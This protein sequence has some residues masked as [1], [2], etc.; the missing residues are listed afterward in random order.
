MRKKLWIRGLALLYVFALFFSLETFAGNTENFSDTATQYQKGVT[1]D[2]NQTENAIE[3][4][5]EVLS[6]LDLSN[7]RDLIFSCIKDSSQS[8]IKAFGCVIAVIFIS[9]VFAI[10]KESFSSF[11]QL[12]DTVGM[13]FLILFTLIPIC[14][15]IDAIEENI[16]RLCAFM[17][18]FIP[19]MTA[20]YVSGGNTTTAVSSSITCTATVGALQLI[21]SKVIIPFVKLGVSLSAVNGICRKADLSGVTGFLRSAGLWI[22]GLS[23]TI[24]T[25]LLSVQ[26]LISNSTDTLALRGIRFS[27]AK[28]IPVAGGMVSESLKTVLSGVSLVRNVAGGAGI[29]FIIYTVIPPVVSVLILKLFCILSSMCAKLSGLSEQSGYL[30]GLNSALNLLLAIVLSCCSAFIIILAIFMKTA[31]NI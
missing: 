29:A 11:S 25:G 15:S 7:I 31:V 24:F 27:A 12:F 18:S 1:N 17:L 20:I 6:A 14:N 13:L 30:D 3:K 10:L 26:T 23:L 9:S 21:G 28:L 16:R 19:S 8:L 22:T 5:K 2:E 4:Q